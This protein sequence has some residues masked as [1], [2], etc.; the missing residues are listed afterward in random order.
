MPLVQE[1]RTKIILHEYASVAAAETI[2]PRQAT[3]KCET[4][5]EILLAV[6]ERSKNAVPDA[7]LARPGPLEISLRE[8][9][10]VEIAKYA[11][12]P[13][14]NGLR[15]EFVETAV[16]ETIVADGKPGE[17]GDP[18]ERRSESMCGC[19]ALC[20]RERLNRGGEFFIGDRGAEGRDTLLPPVVAGIILQRCCDGEKADNKKK[21]EDS[22]GRRTHTQMLSRHPD[23]HSRRRD[24]V[25]ET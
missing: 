23:R 4:A 1:K 2:G 21:A 15:E 6:A 10:G 25:L 20:D 3:A 5:E 14:K 7:V 16:R 8:T 19:M 18:I 13:F 22:S 24:K 12:A 9:S 17:A 11:V